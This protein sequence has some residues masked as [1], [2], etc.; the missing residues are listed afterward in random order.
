MKEYDKSHG[1]PWDRGA[2][3]SYYW[4]QPDPH[5]WTTD[6]QPIFVAEDTPEWEAYMAGFE[7]NE[8]MGDKKRF[9]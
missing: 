1:S 6:R 8:S 5:Y 9:E 3:D 4:R 7:Y 2:A